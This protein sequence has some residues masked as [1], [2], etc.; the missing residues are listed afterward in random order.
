ME[1]PVARS[2][3]LVTATVEAGTLSSVAKLAATCAVTAGA[4][5]A[6]AGSSAPLEGVMEKLKVSRALAL[7][8]PC[9]LA[10]WPTA[11]KVH[12]EEPGPAK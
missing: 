10:G 12:A 6:E 1:A 11:H 9:V 8:Q 2:V 7:A 3:T 5:T 4:A